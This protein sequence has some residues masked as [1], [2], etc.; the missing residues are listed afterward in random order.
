MEK[1]RR[2]QFFGSVLKGLGGFFQPEAPQVVIAVVVLTICVL[3]YFSMNAEKTHDLKVEYA[4]QKNRLARDEAVETDVVQLA[5]TDPTLRYAERQREA[6]GIGLGLSLFVVRQ[7]ISYGRGFSD[8]QSLLN[9]FAKSDIFP[10]QM[11]MLVP[12]Q[13]V[14]Y[15][16][17][18]SGRGL[19]YVRFQPSPLK[20]E[21]LACG[22]DGSESGAVFV[23][24]LPE[25][26][27]ANVAVEQ[28]PNV[29]VAGKWATLFV[30]PASGNAY[31]PPPFAAADV[32]QNSG[33]TI[34]PLRAADIS[35]DKL[36]Q[37]Q[38]FLRSYK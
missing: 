18:A 38:Q 6:S 9:E 20:I 23:L 12:R 35:P 15:G 4:A 7:R 22:S 26:S 27:A 34:E 32:Y 17:L 14:A 31:L 10:P 11:T 30:S 8:V 3:A 19:Y 21:I 13:T 1:N 33:W 2:F 37:I 36:N 5:E 25:T 24:R 29:G 16:I 28:N